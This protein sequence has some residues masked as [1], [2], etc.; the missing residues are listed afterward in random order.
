MQLLCVVNKKELAIKEDYAILFGGNLS[1]LI[2]N[3]Y[4]KCYVLF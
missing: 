2:L 4:R 3:C 1:L